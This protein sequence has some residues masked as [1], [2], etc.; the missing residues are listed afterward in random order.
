[1]QYNK[2]DSLP[3]GIYDALLD[4]RLR[5][6]L[7]SHPEIRSILSKLDPEEQP[8]RY[9]AFI[10]KVIEQ[11]LRQEVNPDVR[12]ALCNR[13]ID[14]ISDDININHF[15]KMRLVQDQESVLEEITPPHYTQQGIP[16][17][18]TSLVESS[19]FTGSPHEPQLSHELLQEMRSADSV[20]ILVSFIKWSGLRLLIP[21]FEDLLM[22]NVPVRVITTS[23]MGV[24][25]PSAVEWLA[26]QPNVEVRVSYDTD[27]TRLHAKAYHF[28]HKSGYSTAYIGSANIS[29][30]AITSGLEWNLK[31]TTQDMQHILNKFCAEFETYWNSKE[32]IRYDLNNP[33]PLREAIRHARNPRTQIPI[34]FFDLR[35]HP[36]QERILDALESER[37]IHGHWHNLIIAAT[38]TGKT[39]IAAFD[40]KRFFERHRSQA[41]LLFVAHRREI[42]EQAIATFR[43]VLRMADFGELLVGPFQPIR[44]DHLFCSVDML[45]SRRLW[46][47]VNKDFYNYIVIDEVHHGPAESYRPIFDH[48]KPRILLGLTATPERMDGKSVAADFGNRLAAE[49]R[50]PEALEEK[51]LCP[52]HYFGVTD[53]VSISEDKFWKN[54]KYDIQELENVY[55]GAHILAGQR[56]DAI[57]NALLRYE[58]DLSLVRGIGFCVSVK[59]AKYMS[60]M[61]NDRGIPSAVL[62]G[63]TNDEARPALLR[64]F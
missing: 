27:R 44:M 43:N 57:L 4:E 22:R 60:Q 13:L 50:L 32:F 52:F 58:P 25:D 62:I 35:P 63:E 23:Y 2:I 9:A 38:G 15:K 47:Q 53:P 36:F 64:N 1:M 7:K 20:D 48:F 19:L 17:P 30:A 55:T 34:A 42:L 21:G 61:F 8:V 14:Q 5:E 29:H 39:V 51:L 10:A 46:E 31:I 41:R 26:K 59:H 37:N 11:V 45:T 3:A 56:L 54:G 24:S 28:Y 12:L 16:R 6:T 49:I 18:V 33:Q 40:F